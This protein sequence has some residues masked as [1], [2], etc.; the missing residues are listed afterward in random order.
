MSCGRHLQVLQDIENKYR[1]GGAVFLAVS[2]DAP[3]YQSAIPGYLDKFSLHC[4]VLL[5]GEKNVP[6]YA[7]ALAPG[8]LYVIDRRGL[9]AGVPSEFRV[10]NLEQELE[11]RL[12][13]LLAGRP[14]PGRV[15]WTARRLPQGWGELWRDPEASGGLHLAV[16]PATPHAPLELM[17]LDRLDHLTRYTGAGVRLGEGDLEEGKGYFELRGADL[18]DDGVNEWLVRAGNNIEVLDSKGRPYWTYYNYDA[19]DK[20]EVEIAG[21][22][23][24]DGDGFKEIVVRSG[25]HVIALGSVGRPRWIHRSTQ[26][27]NGVTVDARGTIWAESD[28][29]LSPIDASGKSGTAVMRAFGFMRIVGETRDG[30]GELLRVL[31]G[32]DLDH[33]VDVDHDLDG[34]GRDDVVIASQNG[35]VAYDPDGRLILSVASGEWGLGMALANLDGRTGDEM[36]LFLPKYGLMA[37]G[38]QDRGTGKAAAGP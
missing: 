28:G 10:S 8:S 25:D 18:D 2:T 38:R 17:L 12:P 6:G 7:D 14:A 30:K 11:R 37:L 16:A 36:V 9:L 1:D 33:R 34:D 26:P 35:V 5:A 29:G 27:L 23:D 3:E 32:R 21:V 13:D 31:D 22:T 20:D 4:R 24:L 15:L 19:S